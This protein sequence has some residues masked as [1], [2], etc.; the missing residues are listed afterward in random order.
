[1]SDRPMIGINTDFRNAA[2]GRTA[3]SALACCYFDCLLSAGAVPILLPP[4]T[5]S[6][7]LS[8]I[9]DRLDGVLLTGGD[10]LDPKKMGLAPHPS[11]TV[12]AERRETADRLLIKLAQMRR[13]PVLGIGVGMQLL[14]VVNGGGNYL[15]L[16]EDMPRG[17][18]HRDPKGGIHRHPVVME[19]GTRLE[20]IY[21][22][23]EVRVNS[24]H[25]QGIR[26]LAPIFRVGAT[27]PDGLIEAFEGKDAG[28]WVTGVQWHPEHEANA[29]L[30]MPLIEA[31]A[32]AAASSR[33]A[34]TL[35]RVG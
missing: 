23:G 19:R 31:F 33:S 34:P 8:P 21:G 5:K 15:H 4:M 27:A 24:Y 16:P 1:M 3:H 26:K 13:M 7:D 18:T 11:V 14:N 29:A 32:S 2:K 28:W 9:L 12:I 22:P 20:E 35:A 25:H 6:D 30:D 10:D 17:L